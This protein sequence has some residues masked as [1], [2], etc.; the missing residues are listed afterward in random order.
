MGTLKPLG[1]NWIFLILF[2][3]IAFRDFLAFPFS[4][5]QSQNYNLNV[6]ITLTGIS[7][8]KLLSVFK[9][10]MLFLNG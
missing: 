5:Y 1:M 8:L 2:G 3:L 4:T 7:F 9:Y 6:S 10:K